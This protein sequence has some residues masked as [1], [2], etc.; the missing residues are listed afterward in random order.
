MRYDSF[1]MDNLLGQDNGL[2]H[3][4]NSAWIGDMS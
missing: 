2:Y 4:P 3:I 1:M